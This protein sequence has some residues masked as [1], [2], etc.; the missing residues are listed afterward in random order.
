MA[1]DTPRPT[2]DQG[3][4]ALRRELGTTAVV[5]PALEQNPALLQSSGAMQAARLQHGK[6]FALQAASGKSKF[7]S[8]GLTEKVYQGLPCF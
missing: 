4:A 7:A 1:S 8:V 3:W 5:L 2:L 6:S